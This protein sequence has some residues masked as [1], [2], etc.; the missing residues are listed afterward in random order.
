MEKEEK[1]PRSRFFE[2]ERP[3]HLDIKPGRVRICDELIISSSIFQMSINRNL[4]ITLL[5]MAMLVLGACTDSWVSI[6]EKRINLVEEAAD[7]LK[8]CQSHEDILDTVEEL[9]SLTE[10]AK[11]IN[12]HHLSNGNKL[13]YTKEESLSM[14]EIAKTNKRINIAKLKFEDGVAHVQP[15]LDSNFPSLNKAIEDFKEQF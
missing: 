13:T 8:S 10:K 11:D 2:S 12:Y 4:K 7:A 1:Y 15:L 3:N 14:E 9:R 6:Q 5:S